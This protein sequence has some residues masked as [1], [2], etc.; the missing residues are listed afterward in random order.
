MTKRMKALARVAAG[1]VLALAMGVVQAQA[2]PPP[3]TAAPSKSNIFYG[4][5]IGLSFGDVDYFEIW[6][7]VGVHIN[8]QLS[9]GI[10][11]VYRHRSDDR[12]SQDLD[13]DDYGS[14]LFARYKVTPNVYLQGEY[15]Y[16]NYEYYRVDLSTD[17]QGFSSVLL[18]GGVSK[19]VGQNASLFATALYNFSYDDPDSPYADPWVIRFGVSAGY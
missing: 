11:L 7:M 16:L 2:E 14:T 8:P 18:G 19:P 9:A 15:E 3:H 17:R 6:P 1:G 13:T 12:F 5:G 4:G 10:T